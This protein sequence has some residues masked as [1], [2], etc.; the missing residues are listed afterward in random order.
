MT[1]TSS[2]AKRRRKNDY[3]P[4]TTSTRGIDYF[5]AKQRG[6]ASA[7]KTQPAK[8]S[9]SEPHSANAPGSNLSQDEILARKLQDEW[10]QEIATENALRT[11]DDSAIPLDPEQAAT[12][13]DTDLNHRSATEPA[14][15]FPSSTPGPKV[16]SLQSTAT[17]EDKLCASIPF[18][19]NTLS[20][21]PSAF[22]PDL[23]NH[24]AADHGHATYSLLTRCFV[25]VN[26]T[27]SRIK[28][29][30]TLTNLLRTIIEADPGSLLPAV[31]LSI[32]RM[33][34]HQN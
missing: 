15:P 18:D 21:N 12:T 30:D 7:P 27:T 31:I 11:A 19:E 9:P 24:W 10:N 13:G 17:D 1:Q 22:L 16:L 34:Q 14:A 5:F 6:A 26:A 8:S 23:Q 33:A 2:P 28:I 29:V 32:S 3:T 20:F 4:G 25:L